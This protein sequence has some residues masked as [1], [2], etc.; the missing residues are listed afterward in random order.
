VLVESGRPALQVIRA[1]LA[2]LRPA[3]GTAE[4]VSGDCYALPAHPALEGAFDVVFVAP[5]YPHFA[6]RKADLAALLASLAA[7]RSPR[8]ADDGVLVVQSDAAD[9]TT[10]E[11]PG[12]RVRARKVWGRTAFTLFV[13]SR[14]GPTSSGNP[15]G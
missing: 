9:F 4:L 1:N 2:T 14:L 3:A 5:P 15:S 12:L 8:L 10:P 6:E 7:G 13:C 11:V